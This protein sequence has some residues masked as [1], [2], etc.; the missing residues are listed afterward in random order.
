MLRL[1]SSHLIP[2]SLSGDS[3]ALSGRLA[4][5]SFIEGISGAGVNL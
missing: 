4:S 1:A 3:K 5:A 2:K